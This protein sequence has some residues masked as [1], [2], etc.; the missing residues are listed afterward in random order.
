VAQEVKSKNSTINTTFL[1]LITPEEA[2]IR[3]TIKLE[4]EDEHKHSQA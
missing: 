2:F 1:W 4:P 3:L